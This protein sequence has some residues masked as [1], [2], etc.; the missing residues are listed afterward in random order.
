ME[1]PVWQRLSHRTAAEQANLMRFADM[2]AEILAAQTRTKNRQ[3][4]GGVLIH[5]YELMYEMCDPPVYEPDPAD[6]IAARASRLGLAPEELAYDIMAVGE[7]D[8]M[9]Y[10]TFANYARGNLDAVREMLEHPHTIPGLSDGGAHVGTICD[11]S[12]PTTLLEHWARDRGDAGLSMPFVVQRQARDTARAVGLHDRGVLR[13][14]YRADVNVIDMTALRLHRPHVLFDLPAGGR[15][16]VQ[17]AEGYRHTIV[18]GQETYQDGAPTGALPG[19]L[20]RG[21][22]SAPATSTEGLAAST[23]R[24]T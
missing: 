11:G 7:G 24:T 5:K 8:A 12:F 20:V 10:L 6:S 23:A 2:R 14:G 16:L 22:Q 9:L 19:H 1:N 21:P 15:R 4:L 18:A 3:R 13:P 17:R